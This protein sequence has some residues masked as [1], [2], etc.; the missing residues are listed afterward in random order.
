MADSEHREIF[1]IKRHVAHDEGHHG[2]AWK[3]AFADFMTA[4]MALFLVLWLISST[5]D[6]TKH[7]VAQY[8]NPVKLVDMTTLKKGFRDPKETEMGSGPNVK[9]SEEES[10]L[11]PAQP[12]GEYKGRCKVSN[13]SKCTGSH[14]SRAFPGSLCGPC[15]YRS[16][17]A[18]RGLGIFVGRGIR[19][20]DRRRPR[21]VQRSFYNNA[22]RVHLALSEFRLFRKFPAAL[23]VFCY[24][25]RPDDKTKPIH[26]T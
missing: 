13:R 21:H 2:G 16:E 19:R 7:T 20:G 15:G 22:Q 11:E 17:Q 8:F 10:E 3:I 18:C 9:P 12:L 5:S 4:M 6:K 1:I 14:R 25:F 23:C 24:S 26:R